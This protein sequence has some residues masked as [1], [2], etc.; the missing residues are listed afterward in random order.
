MRFKLIANQ[1]YRVEADDLRVIVRM[2]ADF[3]QVI[4]E[5][6]SFE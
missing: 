6:Y 2:I 5:R 3:C 4:G 1:S